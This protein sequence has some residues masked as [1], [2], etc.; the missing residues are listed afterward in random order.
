MSSRPLLARDIYEKYVSIDNQIK[1]PDDDNEKRLLARAILGKELIAR[2]DYWL[3]YGIDLVFD[4]LKI[5]KF[6]QQ[7]IL[8]KRKAYFYNNFHLLTD[9]QKAAIRYLVRYI[10]N[11][12][13]FSNLV[14]LDQPH[15]GNYNF[16]LKISG[17]ETEIS[18]LSDPL[19]DLH[20]E[21]NN[22]LISFSKYGDEIV[23]LVETKS[24]WQFKSKEFELL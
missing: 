4:E 5:S 1:I 21:L 10:S 6:G 7:S 16:M 3:T 20:D 22:W 15:F 23:E 17:S 13:L 18:I 14:A 11:G 9:T 24:G 8:E 12:I 2:F 19:N